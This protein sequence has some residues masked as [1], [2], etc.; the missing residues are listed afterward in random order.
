MRLKSAAIFRNVRQSKAL[1]ACVS[2]KTR[3]L[4][5]RLVHP[6]RRSP[7]ETNPTALKDLHENSHVSGE[8]E[9]KA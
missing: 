3:R 5:A 6:V 9:H 2:G 4:Q 7:A 1:R 8:S